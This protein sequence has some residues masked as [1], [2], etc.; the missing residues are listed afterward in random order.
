[1]TSGK[2]VSGALTRFESTYALR[3][4]FSHSVA[5]SADAPLTP[6]IHADTSWLL[7]LTSTPDFQPQRL[8]LSC[9]VI[10][11]SFIPTFCLDYSGCS[12]PACSQPLIMLSLRDL[13]EHPSPEA[14]AHAHAFLS[15]DQGLSLGPY[16]LS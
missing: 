10:F 16:V 1:M 11:F 4:L 8:L 2:Q 14:E 13:V 9:G 6:R 3:P 7:L 15:G 12:C 5:M